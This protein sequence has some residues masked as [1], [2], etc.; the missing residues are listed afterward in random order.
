[1][2]E[3]TT[4]RV[5]PESSSD[6]LL[7][8]SPSSSCCCALLSCLGSSADFPGN[9]VH[10]MKRCCMS[11][12]DPSVLLSK[13]ATVSA[14]FEQISSAE[15]QLFWKLIRSAPR[16]RESNKRAI[17]SDPRAMSCVSSHNRPD[18]ISKRVL[19]LSSWP[20]AGTER[21]A[22]SFWEERSILLGGNARIIKS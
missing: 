15:D 17:S 9:N 11:T 3:R 16:R 21:K 2:C 10:G 4:S 8:L 19:F 20:R 1:M 7:A 13:S 18:K 14:I 6:F 12:R 5:L 22:S